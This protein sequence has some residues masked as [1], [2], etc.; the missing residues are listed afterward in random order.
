[1]LC[2]S[3]S[4]N[5]S[6]MAAWVQAIG[7]IIA[8]LAGVAAVWWQN[9][10]FKLSER[11]R[12]VEKV[13][14]VAMLVRLAAEASERW[15]KL[16]NSDG[17]FD[18]EALDQ[19]WRTLKLASEELNRIGIDQVLYAVV[20]DNLIKARECV[21]AIVSLVEPNSVH[22]PNPSVMSSVIGNIHCLY[23]HEENMHA[24]SRRIEQGQ[25]ST[26]TDDA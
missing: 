24:E 21:Q 8:I 5:S 6:E 16:L 17:P 22:T 19:H 25:R 20:V 23:L 26:N 18:R 9:R 4:L 7:A 3:T 15:V 1:M 10:Q 11:N 13:R 14:A 12:S 2:L